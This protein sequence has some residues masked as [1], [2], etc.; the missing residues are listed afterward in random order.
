MFGISTKFDHTLSIVSAWM[1]MKNAYDY[2]QDKE[3][4]PG[5]LVC[6]SVDAA[7]PVIN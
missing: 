6:Y 5:P 4:D 2:V 1:E 7:I 3:V